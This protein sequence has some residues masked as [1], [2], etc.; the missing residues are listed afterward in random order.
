MSV[1]HTLI[2]LFY[3]LYLKSPIF[4]D[5]LTDFGCFSLYLLKIIDVLFLIMQTLFFLKVVLL[6]YYLILIF[7][8]KSLT[9]HFFISIYYQSFI[10]YFLRVFPKMLFSFLFPVLI[11]IVVISNY[12]DLLSFL[13]ILFIHLFVSLFELFRFYFFLIIVRFFNLFLI[14]VNF[15]N[16]SVFYP[17]F[18]N[19]LKFIFF[20]GQVH[21]RLFILPIHF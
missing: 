12:F 17:W 1:F 9:N 18:F 8:T 5:T 14:Y 7:I 13:S 10:K 20:I 11:F 15:I 6:W 19:L 4:S 2:N 21:V 3:P 16:S